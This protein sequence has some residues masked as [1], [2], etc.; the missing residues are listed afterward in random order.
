M[1]LVNN[2][3]RELWT[4]FRPRLSEISNRLGEELYNLQVYPLDY[5]KNFNPAVEYEAYA[6]VEVSHADKLPADMVSFHLPAGDYA[7]FLHK[8]GPATASRTFQFILTE[9]LPNSEYN[10]DHRPHFEA[11]GAKYSNTSPDSEEEIW[12]P[13]R[14]S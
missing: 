3:T 1:S 5:Y 6:L 10:L 7:V 13:V 4:R 14:R 2:R 12:L 11:L 9:W 8:G